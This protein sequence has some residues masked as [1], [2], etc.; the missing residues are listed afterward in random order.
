LD[1]RQSQE[2]LHCSGLCNLRI[3][4]QVAKEGSQG[5]SL[6]LTP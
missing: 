1:G 6:V 4:Q 3:C 5:N 2:V